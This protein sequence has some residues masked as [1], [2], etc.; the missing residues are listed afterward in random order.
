MLGHNVRIVFGANTDVGKSLILGGLLRTRTLH[1]SLPTNY[2]KPLQCG[3]PDDE[4]FINKY[5]PKADTKTL[6]DFPD[7]ACS[8][9]LASV[10]TDTS[11]SDSSLLKSL[12]KAA[13]AP[14]KSTAVYIETAGGVLSPAASFTSTH[15]HTM[16]PLSPS[17]LHIQHKNSAH[18][19]TT[20]GDL[21][22]PLAK[23]VK[24]LLVA[25]SRLGGVSCTL[26]AIESLRKR[27][28]RVDAVVFLD[29][30]GP[31]DPLLDN[32]GCVSDYLRSCE[33]NEDARVFS[34]PHPPPLPET[35]FEYFDE[36]DN[37]AIFSELDAHLDS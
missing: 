13:T 21:Y 9:H 16:A 20:Q 36:P 6:F 17:P 29:S 12:H 31:Q 10:A 23:Q 4:S 28:F 33:S 35:L 25:D 11:V 27:N 7:H 5:A 15:P 2:I 1:K 22:S 18:F 24:T 37:V 30:K 3:R 14:L 8:P 19:Y 26:S 34:L 32:K